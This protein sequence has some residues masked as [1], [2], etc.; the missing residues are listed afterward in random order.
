MPEP[1]PPPVLALDTPLAEVKEI[2]ARVRKG[3][4]TLGLRTVGGLLAYLPIKHERQ[5]AEGEIAEVVPGAIVS[6]RGT[7]G[8]TRV[9]GGARAG[10]KGRF[11]VVLNDGTRSAMLVWFNQ[12]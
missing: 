11:E 12:V 8:A 1:T 10:P 5:E 9:V 7:V 3:L 4:V 2:P 6:F